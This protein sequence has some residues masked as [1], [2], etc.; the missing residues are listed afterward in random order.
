MFKQIQRKISFLLLL[1][2]ISA[3][4]VVESEPK[5]PTIDQ[6]IKVFFF[7]DRGTGGLKGYQG[8]VYA[9]TGVITD[10]SNKPSDWKYVKTNWGQNTTETKL[11]RIA[12][13]LYEFVINDIR[14]YYNVPNSEKIL[15]LG[16]VFRSGDNQ[17]EGKAKGGADI[18]IELFES[19]TQVIVTEPNVSRLSPFMTSIDT[20]V[21]IT[22]IGNSI[23]SDINKMLIEIDGSV[24]T[25]S[26]ND[27]IQYE[28][29]LNSQG[30]KIVSAI[31]ID[32]LGR[33]DTATFQLVYNPNI[34][35]IAVPEGMVDG[36]NYNSNNSVTL[37]L[38]APHKNNI[39][40]IGDFNDWHLDPNYFMNRDKIND[41]STRWWI[42]LSGLEVGKEYA[43]QYFVDGKIRIADPYA[44]KILDP[45]NDNDIP[46]TIYPGLKPYPNGKTKFPVSI[47]EIGQV[48]YNWGTKGYSIPNKENL[49]IYELLIR[50]FVSD[51][52]YKTLIDSLDY[53]KNLGINAI[54]LMPFNEFEGNSS[55]GYNPSF[56][57]APDKY[58]GT[59]NELKAFIDS[60]HSNGIAV[61]MDLV[62]NHAYGQSPFVRLYNDGDYGKPTEENPWF[63]RDHNFANKNAHWGYDWDHESSVTQYVIDR[64]ITYWMNEYKIDGF[65]FDF[66]K[67][68]GNNF[69][70]NNDEWG[71]L[72]DI[73][74]IRLLKRI[75]DHVWA[76]NKNGIVI[77]EHLAEEK[78]EKELADY[79]MLM[80][81]N[82]HYN[83]GEA[84]MG[85]HGGTQSNLSWTYF[86]NRGWKRPMMV[87]YMESHDEE[88]IMVKA[89]KYGA[90]YGNHNVKNLSV[91]LERMK[92]AGALFF[93]IPG[94]KMMWQ[95]GEIGYDIS[96]DYNGRLAEKPIKWDYLNDRRR[97]DLYDTWSYL[98]NLQKQHPIF[99]NSE[100]TLTTWLSNSVKKIK[101]SYNDQHSILI[102]NFDVKMKDVTVDLPHIGPWH[103]LFL[104][105]TITFNN[106]SPSIKLS[107]GTFILLT[108]FEIDY[109][110]KGQTHLLIND[111][112]SIPSKISVLDNYP[113]PFNPITTIHFLVGNSQTEININIYDMKG[114][115]IE[116]LFSDYLSI[117][118]YR[119][120]WNAVDQSSGIYFV[121]LKSDDFEQ[122]QKITL[123]K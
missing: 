32:V 35:D 56:L 95:F 5:F 103:H 72:Y 76:Q 14:S 30:K 61:I 3:Q 62:L 22:A 85:Y 113:N 77:L 120:K 13:D 2:F 96:I 24:V 47:F 89:L 23:G 26:T 68:I 79:G 92:T 100:S 91:A 81:A 94:P 58:Y 107:P 102:A 65:R 52:H 41:D 16:F 119:L 44:D 66:T 90:K 111:D 36:I 118:E 122:I 83:Y 110:Q 106:L 74:R 63:N 15:K 6:S 46:D 109:P 99:H 87:T 37:S 78:E 123:I 20:T 43:F 21:K 71:S 4:Y 45:W 117:G 82:A 53:L 75:A 93:L 51:H 31:A 54:E 88:R 11:T 25:S 18:F 55:W 70:E 10:Q 59:K 8:D 121:R 115:L 116:T 57:F 50:D 12:T 86:K 29:L 105:D 114:R 80:W 84:V 104:G 28:V 33:S 97:K 101:Y 34:M 73:D 49:I 60:C 108:D 69:K 9:H 27:T 112:N 67:G 1:S 98:I 48:N 7:A 19:G 40:V 38:F 64:S 17:K 39:Y 42:T